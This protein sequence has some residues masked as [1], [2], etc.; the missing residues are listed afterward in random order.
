[1]ECLNGVYRQNIRGVSF[2]SIQQRFERILRIDEKTW[3][4]DPQAQS[5]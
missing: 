4:N 3:S 1:M 2:N 5:P